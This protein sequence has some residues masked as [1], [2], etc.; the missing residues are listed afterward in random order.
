MYYDEP[1]ELDLV[2]AHTLAPIYE[3]LPSDPE[4]FYR[5]SVSVQPRRVTTKILIHTYYMTIV[6]KISLHCYEYMDWI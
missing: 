6:Q 3:N 2:C 4:V 5:M 1:T